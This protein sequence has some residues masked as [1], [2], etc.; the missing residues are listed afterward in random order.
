MNYKNIYL[1]LCSRGKTNRNLDY[2]ESHHIVPRCM[3]G[4]DSEDNLTNLTAKEHYIAHLLLTKIHNNISLMY[5][6]GMMGTSSKKTKRRYTSSQYEKMKKSY[7]YAMKLNNPMFNHDVRKKVSDTRKT[8]FENGSL[9]P[10]IFSDDVKKILSDK[11]LGDNNPIRKDPSKNRTAQ[12]IRIYFEDGKIEE[13]SYAKDY[14]LKSGVPYATMK[15]W[16][17]NN[18]KSKK[19]G[20]IRIEKI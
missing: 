19:H 1:N 12:P 11:M 5:A 17:R 18:I 2:S 20:I 10:V 16:L 6:F 8:M 13:Y 14:C 4:V 3:G 7:S 9:K 15:Y